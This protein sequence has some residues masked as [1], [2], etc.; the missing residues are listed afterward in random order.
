MPRAIQ[1]EVTPEVTAS[2]A[3]SLFARPGDGSVRARKVAF[4]VADG[5]DAAAVRALAERLAAEGAVPRLLGPRIGA[6]ETMSGETLDADASIETTPSVLYDGVVLP[7][8]AAAVKALGANGQVLEFVK[9]Q[10]RHCKTMLAFGA[11]AEV[12]RAA[13]IPE[14]LPDGTADPGVIA[15]ATGAG[16]DLFIQALAKHRH[17]ARETDPP[18]V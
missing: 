3:L 13:G 15:D 9:D 10:Y 1:R 4:L 12:L 5:C 2:A 11:G 18:R 7:D 8:G 17:F 6:V 16:S 14:A